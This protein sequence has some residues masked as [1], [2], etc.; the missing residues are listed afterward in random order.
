MCPAG[1]LQE[2]AEPRVRDSKAGRVG[3]NWGMGIGPG[4][5]GSLF[6]PTFTGM[7]DNRIDFGEG[8]RLKRRFES[9]R[10]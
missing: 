5:W 3:S 1:S 4:P 6:G 2:E 7:R 8:I 10:L 9:R